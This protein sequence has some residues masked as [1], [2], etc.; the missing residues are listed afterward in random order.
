MVGDTK[1]VHI[2]ADAIADADFDSLA[3]MSVA[4]EFPI[5]GGM[6]TIERTRAMTMIDIDGGSDAMTLNLAAAREIPRL[7]QLLDIG[8]QIGIDF[9][10]LPDRR[11]RLALDAALA[12][13][14]KK[15]GSH[16]RTAINGFGFVQIVRQR[17]GASIPEILCG[18][19][20]GRLSLDSRAVALLRAA[21]ISTGHGRRTLTAPPKIVE[22]IKQW[23]ETLAKLRLSLGADI[24]LVSD[25]F[26]TG[27]GHVHVSQS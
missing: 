8:G 21:A 10:T 4:G 2:D 17:I 11:A 24:E 22:R 26:M 25:S 20:S 9:L 15:L 1:P 18:I 23:P 27:D 12:E 6:L 5:E 16:E 13:S 7:L 3:E 19:T 14:C